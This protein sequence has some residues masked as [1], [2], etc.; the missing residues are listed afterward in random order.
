MHSLDSLLSSKRVE[1]GGALIGLNLP[2]WLAYAKQFGFSLNELPKSDEADSPILIDGGHIFCKEVAKLW[3][4]LD[5]VLQS[6][7]GDDRE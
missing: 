6:M 5:Q 4:A 1:A 7:N 3:S 2:T